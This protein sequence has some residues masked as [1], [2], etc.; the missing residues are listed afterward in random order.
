MSRMRWVEADTDFVVDDRQP[1]GERALEML[2]EASLPGERRPHPARRFLLSVSVLLLALVGFELYRFI[3]A[4]FQEHWAVGAAFTALVALVVISGLAWAGIEIRALR[5][6]DSVD[7]ARALLQAHAG[8]DASAEA[9]RVIAEVSAALSRRPSLAPALSRYEAE[10]QDTHEMP[11]RLALFSR[12]VLAVVD[13]DAYRA[14]GRAARDV[15]VLTAIVPTA[16]ADTA[17]LVWRNVRMIR[18]IAELYGYRTG[19]VG[20]WVL[21]RRLLSNAALVAATDVAGGILAQ[22]LGGALTEVVAAKLGGSAV[23]TTRTL[24]MGLLTM[25]LCRAVPFS[26]EDAPNL[27]RFAMAILGQD[28]GPRPESP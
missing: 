6:L 12:N 22:Q 7:R 1:E 18:E 17:V 4:R 9:A 24:R 2:P 3:L 20:T 14:V 10:V 15:G 5:R 25:Q 28:A 16:I 21:I 26:E 13:R 19:P 11:Q 27:R 23:A 8:Q